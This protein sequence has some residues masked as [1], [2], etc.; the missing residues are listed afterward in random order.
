MRS[1]HMRPDY[2]ALCT[3]CGALVA[4]SDVD[5]DVYADPLQILHPA[6]GCTAM[7]QIA[8]RTLTRDAYFTTVTK[9]RVDRTAAQVQTEAVR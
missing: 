7:A 3:T 1:E 6:N 9:L 5:V 8:A 2:V 4:F